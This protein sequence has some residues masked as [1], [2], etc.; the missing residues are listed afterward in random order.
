MGG[1][2]PSISPSWSIYLLQLVDSF[3]DIEDKRAKFKV[4]ICYKL[5]LTYMTFTSVECLCGVPQP[6]IPF[7]VFFLVPGLR[8]Y[9]YLSLNTMSNFNVAFSPGTGGNNDKKKRKRKKKKKADRADGNKLAN[10][11]DSGETQRV[12]DFISMGYT[13]AQVHE[14]FDNMFQAG[15]DMNNDKKVKECLHRM[16]TGT[17]IQATQKKNTSKNMAGSSNNNNNK[18][19]NGY[20]NSSSNNSSSSATASDNT[21]KSSNPSTVQSAANGNA[22]RSSTAPAEPAEPQKKAEQSL[23]ERLEE[24]TKMPAN[25]VMPVLIKWCR[26]FPDERPVLFESRALQQLFANFLTDLMAKGH[27][28]SPTER[29]KYEQPMNELLRLAV[30]S[31]EVADLV[32]EQL[33]S[34]VSAASSMEMQSTEIKSVSETCA[35]SLVQKIRSFHRATTYDERLPQQ[36]NQ[37]TQQLQEISAACREAEQKLRTDVDNLAMM[38]EL[39][40]LRSEMTNL[41]SKK[42]DLLSSVGNQEVTSSNGDTKTKSTKKRNGANDSKKSTDST[43]LISA[44]F[45]SSEIEKA[46]SSHSSAQALKGQIHAMTTKQEKSLA[47]VRSALSKTQTEKRSLK[48]RA[49]A[50]KKELV[51]VESRLEECM[52]EEEK[53]LVE[54]TRL[55]QVFDND[56]TSLN[57]KNDGLVNQLRRAESQ[58]DIVKCLRSLEIGIAKLSKEKSMNSADGKKKRSQEAQLLAML[59]GS[60]G[61]AGTKTSAIQSS[62]EYVDCEQRCMQRIRTRVEETKSSISKGETELEQISKLGLGKVEEHMRATL[63]EQQENM[64]ED[65]GLLAHLEGQAREMFAAVQ[66]VVSSMVNVDRELAITIGQIKE[67]FVALQCCGAA[68][69]AWPVPAVSR[70]RETSNSGGFDTDKAAALGLSALIPKN[71]DASSSNNSSA[72]ESKERSPKAIPT[73]AAAQKA[74]PPAAPA[75]S[76]FKGWGAP[77]AAAATQKSLATIQQEEMLA[78]RGGN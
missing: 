50:L 24:A 63:A 43:V 12:K 20:T 23:E 58:L 76:T 55:E 45:S 60:G 21:A 74:P 28:L 27:A 40:D 29:Q 41:L 14:C 34:F 19:G 37:L 48:E 42:A 39:R 51:E 6:L 22:T 56:M 17:S 66:N 54:Q 75:V 13:R 70:G 16:K 26:N 69:S 61:V 30:A 77:K 15:E 47:P 78:A 72:E 44:G 31:N 1:C 38:F 62:L 68:A 52:I 25:I 46:S 49:E 73:K 57:G 18:D 3:F 71:Y 33:S 4:Y 65:M 35:T 32:T 10:G 11:A 9:K 64:S 5:I 36:L 8:I 53:C 59:K 67:G 2:L 7:T